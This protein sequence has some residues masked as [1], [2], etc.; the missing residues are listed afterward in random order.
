MFS[1]AFYSTNVLKV[2]IFNYILC[3]QLIFSFSSK[4]F[5]HN[6]HYNGNIQVYILPSC[7][8]RTSFGVILLLLPPLPYLFH[9][10]WSGGPYYFFCDH[11]GL[12]SFIQRYKRNSCHLWLSSLHT[13]ISS[14]LLCKDH[15]C[16]TVFLGSIYFWS[17]PLV[18][19]LKVV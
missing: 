16:Q 6:L 19:V 17:F 2:N 4:L 9:I 1:G 7:L 3:I 8:P 10:T 13:F 15:S 5:L 11:L 14:L 12:L 18:G